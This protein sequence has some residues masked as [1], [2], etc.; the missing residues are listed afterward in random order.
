MPTWDE[1]K[2]IA[3][4]RGS[5]GMELYVVESSPLVPGPELQATLP[6]HLA[7]QKTLE[8]DGSLFLACPVSDPTGT[9]M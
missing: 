3:R 8:A 4:K 1:Y 5:L 6:D 7:Y 9:Q 2:S